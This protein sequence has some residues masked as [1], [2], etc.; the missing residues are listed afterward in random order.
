MNLAITQEDIETIDISDWLNRDGTLN[1]PKM[2][3]SIKKE[4]LESY[5]RTMRWQAWA[6]RTGLFGRFKIKV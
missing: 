5:K 1:T 3:A 4:I 6:L 2:Q